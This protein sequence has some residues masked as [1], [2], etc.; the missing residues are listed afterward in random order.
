MA[1]LLLPEGVQPDI[2]DQVPHRPP[3]PP[4]V[5]RRYRPHAHSIRVIHAPLNSHHPVYQILCGDQHDNILWLPDEDTRSILLSL[6]LQFPAPL[7][8]VDDDIPSINKLRNLGFDVEFHRHTH[9]AFLQAPRP[10]FLS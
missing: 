1:T 7:R 10:V 9:N 4:Y 8:I 5:V 6:C 3:A 2:L